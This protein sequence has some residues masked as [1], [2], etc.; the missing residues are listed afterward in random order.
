MTKYTEPG[1]LSIVYLNIKVKRVVEV[2]GA[3]VSSAAIKLIILPISSL[4]T[5]F[6]RCDL[7]TMIVVPPN[8]KKIHFL[9]RNEKYAISDRVVVLS[10]MH[11]IYHFLYCLM[12]K[13]PYLLNRIFI[14][15][16]LT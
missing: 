2:T 7:I 15:I 11:N 9:D 13:L 4:S 5:N 1:H 12:I 3:N 8:A 6:A 16:K 10:H 14:I